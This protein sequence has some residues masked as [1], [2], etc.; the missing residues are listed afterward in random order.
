MDE[1]AM[2]DY[3]AG[4]AMAALANKALSYAAIAERAYRQADAMMKERTKWTTPNNPNSPT[5]S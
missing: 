5:P 3:F 1:E 4:Q 2:R